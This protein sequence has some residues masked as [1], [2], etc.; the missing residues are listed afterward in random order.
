MKT[1]GFPE[2]PKVL[3]EALEQKFP[4]RLPDHFASID[5][6]RMLQGEQRVVRFL[7]HQ[8]DQQNKVTLLEK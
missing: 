8:F 3:L 1:K 7:R 5:E 2:I 4:D 6:L